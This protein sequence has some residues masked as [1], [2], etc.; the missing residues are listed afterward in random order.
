MKLLHVRADQ[1][2]AIL[3][4]PIPRDRPTH[5]QCAGNDDYNI[6]TESGKRLVCGHCP[7]RQ[8]GKQRENGDQIVAKPSP[9]E[10]D[11]GPAK[12]PE[13]KDLGCGHRGVVEDSSARTTE[14][15][16]DINSK[17]RLGSI[18]LAPKTEASG[19]FY[20]TQVGI[21]PM[22]EFAAKNYFRR[23]VGGT[24]TSLLK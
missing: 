19:I 6:V 4:D 3:D 15:V 12:N 5:H 10:K 9:D 17:F 22:T 23:V 16:A 11:H 2:D 20:E 24:K 18:F 14:T 1:A 8:R 7:G 21:H 13:S